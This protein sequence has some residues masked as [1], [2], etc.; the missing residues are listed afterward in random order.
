VDAPCVAFEAIEPGDQ[1]TLIFVEPPQHSAVARVVREVKDCPALERADIAA[2]YFEISASEGTE[3]MG[4]AIA[5]KGKR[6]V[7]LQRDGVSVELDSR[8]PRE[9]FKV[10]SSY[11]GLHLTI[12]S[13]PPLKGT[14][15]WHRYFYLGYDVEPS[16][17]DAE[18]R[19]GVDEDLP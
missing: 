8:S 4:I 9:L 17:T 19:T 2:P 7:K 14:R 13:G 6:D 18:A 16:C 10:C 1:L 3:D 15:R 12:W 5:L 11:E